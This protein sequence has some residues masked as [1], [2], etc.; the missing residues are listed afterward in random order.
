MNAKTAKSQDLLQRAL[1]SLPGDVGLQS[2]RKHIAKALQEV[3]HYQ[4][5]K[6]TSKPMSVQQQW[7]L[8]M[9]TGG[10]VNPLTK[11]QQKT[12]LSQLDKFIEDEHKKIKEIKQRAVGNQTL[13]G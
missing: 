9:K 8:D 12:A 6:E 11:E 7:Q 13:L 3:A 4:T 1:K 10:L 2:A 5:K